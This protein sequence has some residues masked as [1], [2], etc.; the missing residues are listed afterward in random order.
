MVWC[1]RS[2]IIVGAGGKGSYKDRRIYAYI[3]DDPR[4]AFVPPYVI[5]R[6]WSCNGG[7]V[8]ISAARSLPTRKI[9]LRPPKLF[10]ND[11]IM[12]YYLST[13][14]PGRRVEA[15]RAWN[16]VSGA[17]CNI[18]AKIMQ[19]SQYAQS[20]PPRRRLARGRAIFIF[21]ALDTTRVCGRFAS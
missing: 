10:R 6:A 15:A 11:L 4:S 3:D 21:I 13:G 16:M 14:M 20:P 9:P 1:G 2:W 5:S 19:N 17:T 8:V 7:G 12:Y 18:D